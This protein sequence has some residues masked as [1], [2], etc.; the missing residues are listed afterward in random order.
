[1]LRLSDITWLRDHLVGDSVIF[2]AAGY[3]AMAIETIYQKTYATG[4]IPEG[5]SISELPCKLRNVTFPRMLTLDTKS[6][7]YIL[8]SL[9]PCSSTKES[10]HEFTVSTITKDGSIE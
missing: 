8:L 6:G 1:M 2:P 5:T 4:Q 3:I 10:W 7:T 9:Q